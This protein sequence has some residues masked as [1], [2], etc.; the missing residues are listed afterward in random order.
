MPGKRALPYLRTAVERKP[1]ITNL[2]LYCSPTSFI[3]GIASRQARQAECQ[4]S[5]TMYL[6]SE[7]KSARYRTTPVVSNNSPSAN[8]SP[9]PTAF[10]GKSFSAIYRPGSLCF[11]PSPSRS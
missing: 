9:I 8:S 5:S 7:R 10:G 2:S 11:Q 1:T 4:K 6:P 3:S